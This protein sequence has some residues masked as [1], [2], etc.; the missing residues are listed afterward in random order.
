MK[1]ISVLEDQIEKELYELNQIQGLIK[2]IHQQQHEPEA[3][4]QDHQDLPL[5]P[6]KNGQRQTRGNRQA[7]GAEQY[8]QGFEASDGYDRDGGSF[9]QDQKG[10][11]GLQM[12]NAGLN[13]RSAKELSRSPI[14]K[15]GDDRRRIG[16]KEDKENQ[17][18]NNPTFDCWQ[19]GSPLR[20]SSAKK[21][22]PA[23]KMQAKQKEV[24]TPKKA[25][26]QGQEIDTLRHQLGL[27]VDS[28]NGAV[29]PFADPLSFLEE[30]SQNVGSLN[31]FIN[32]E[33]SNQ[34]RNKEGRSGCANTK[35]KPKQE[36]NITELRKILFE[37]QDSEQSAKKIKMKSALKHRKNVS[38]DQSFDTDEQEEDSYPSG[39]LL[40]ES[41][42]ASIQRP[43]KSPSKRTDDVGLEQYQ[44]L[45]HKFREARKKS[46]N[47]EERVNLMILEKENKDIMKAVLKKAK[48]N[49]E[50]F[51][52]LKQC[53]F[54]PKKI[55]QYRPEGKSPG[56]LTKPFM[57]RVED[58]D[59]RRRVKIER[60]KEDRE[61]S[62]LAGCTFQPDILSQKE[63]LGRQYPKELRK[64]SF[65][66]NGLL[67]Y[68]DR[69]NKVRSRS[70][71]KSAENSVN[72]ARR[73]SVSRSPVPRHTQERQEARESVQ[74]KRERLGDLLKTKYQKKRLG[75]HEQL[76]TIPY[77]NNH[78]Y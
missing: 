71:L 43:S 56:R 21:K 73:K 16:V 20:N 58:W 32:L 41:S 22:K 30:N 51:N 46:T 62:S 68:Y 18:G 23:I 10:R 39:T 13:N 74:S 48:Q 9:Q 78:Y 50:A 45:C 49:E 27:N 70:P 54:T 52:E 2:N 33:K 6:R 67:E 7:K 61:K 55:S 4:G 66:Q 12:G 44:K 64:S 53:T 36:D 72:S 63:D 25:S 34:R 15:K 60:Q 24:R 65:L 17:R 42:S 19:N 75:L 77:N 31:E 29:N 37:E 69:M 38:E 47:F 8:C 57:E 14:G 1:S 76:M 40:N 5:Q 26:Y 35:A 28:E 59:V 3:A 11:Q